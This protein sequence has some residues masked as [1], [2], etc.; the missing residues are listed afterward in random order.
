[1]AEGCHIC[2]SNIVTCTRTYY[3]AFRFIYLFCLCMAYKH[4]WVPKKLSRLVQLFPKRQGTY[5]PFILVRD[6]GYIQ[7]ESSEKVDIVW[8]TIVE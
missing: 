5:L 7:K 2:K 6:G 1:M 8:F 4:T 3:R